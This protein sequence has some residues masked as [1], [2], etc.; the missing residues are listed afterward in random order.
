MLNELKEAEIDEKGGLLLVFK[1][2][3][4]HHI[5]TYQMNLS[6]NDTS[7]LIIRLNKEVSKF[8]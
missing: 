8:L 7:K 6:I 3:D 2:G 4:N 5:P 1:N